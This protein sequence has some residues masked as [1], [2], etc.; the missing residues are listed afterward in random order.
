MESGR[1]KKTWIL[2]GVL[3]AIVVIGLVVYGCFFR[4]RQLQ[5][6]CEMEKW[7]ALDMVAEVIPGEGSHSL[8]E[9]EVPLEDLRELLKDVSVRR[10]A[11]TYEAPGRCVQF[12]IR[13]AENGICNLYVGENGAI[14]MQQGPS[15]DRL[16]TTCWKTNSTELYQAVRTLIGV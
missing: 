7:Q 10:T 6:V 13:T 11:T 8:P 3:S 5:D 2:A 4:T 14:H 12:W 9:D 16:Q 15:A 1:R